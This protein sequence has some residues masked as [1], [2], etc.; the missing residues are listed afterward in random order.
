MSKAGEATATTRFDRVPLGDLLRNEHSDLP[1][2]LGT[3]AFSV[4]LRSNST[5]ATGS[6]MHVIACNERVCLRRHSY[7]PDLVIN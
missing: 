3:G 7:G 5:K 2:H 6:F 4:L 1:W